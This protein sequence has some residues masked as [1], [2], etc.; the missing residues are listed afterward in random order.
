MFVLIN[1][2]NNNQ[3]VVQEPKERSK[4]QIDSIEYVK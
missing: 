1:M 2:L 4:Q 3:V